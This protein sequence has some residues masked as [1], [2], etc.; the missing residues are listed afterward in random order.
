MPFEQ[1]QA[2]IPQPLD[3]IPWFWFQNGDAGDMPAN[4]VM[5]LTSWSA[6]DPEKP[7]FSAVKPTAF[8]AQFSHAINDN[9][10]VGTGQW[11][12]CYLMQT[13]PA[14]YDD[15]DGTPA[16]G[17]IWGPRDNTWKLKKNTGGFRIAGTVDTTNKYV[18]VQ[19]YP[20][21]D[22]RGIADGTIGA[23][24][25]GT[26]SIYYRN[27]STSSPFYTDT[28]VNMDNVVN[29]LDASVSSGAMV[30]V[31]WEPRSDGTGDW[32]IYQADC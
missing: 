15:A 25:R 27:A 21:L 32:V 20:F 10:V 3:I 4:A 23:D 19:P 16:F 30:R 14:L 9:A 13:V 18:L 28:T 24:A 8:G 2:H 1:I 11:G 29:D 17:E 5:K 26:V 31:R 7:F 6:A 12:R 22:F